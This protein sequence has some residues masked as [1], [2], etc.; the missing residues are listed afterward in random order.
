MN[1]HEQNEESP[2]LHFVTPLKYS[3]AL[4]KL[5][6]DAT[7]VY[8]KM[9]NCQPSGSFKN[10]GIGRLARKVRHFVVVNFAFENM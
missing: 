1:S 5:I 7:E 9:E 10:R 3:K 8:M 4:S 2:S 6:P